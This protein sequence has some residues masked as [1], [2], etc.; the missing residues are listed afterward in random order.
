MIYNLQIFYLFHKYYFS[1]RNKFS[2]TIETVLSRGRLFTLSKLSLLRAVILVSY[3]RNICI[4]KDYKTILFGFVL[5]ILWFRLHIRSMIAFVLFLIKCD[6]W[7][8]FHF[9][10]FL[11]TYFFPV[12]F[13]EIFARPVH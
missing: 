3:I 12:Q 11:N 5:E 2:S 13:V 10:F 7:V 1:G 6:M 9:F 8:K 4:T